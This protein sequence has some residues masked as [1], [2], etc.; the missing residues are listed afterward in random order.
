MLSL[1]AV[2]LSFAPAPLRAPQ[3]V[4]R[5]GAVS[6]ES[7]GDLKALADKCNPLVG[8]WDPMNLAEYDQ[9]SQ[10]EE[11]AIGFL[12]HA[13]IKHGRVA[14]AAF[15]GYCLQA[16]GAHFPWGLTDS[17]SFGDISA[18]G[19]PN[20]QWDALPTLAKLQIIAAIGLLEYFGE[21]D[22]AL[23]NSGEKHYM[24]GGTPGFYPS[25][26]SAGVPHP[27]P[28]DLWD[29]FGFTKGMSAE[30]KAKSLKAEINNGRL[31]MIGIMGFLAAEKVPG[32]VPFLDGLVA[33]YSG[34]VMAPFL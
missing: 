8:F 20:E 13:E 16:N 10:G 19:Y 18:A 3:S 7:A 25:L 6:M 15:V 12:R 23:G 27:V 33:P 21:S 14:M 30:K 17:V 9:W 34:D 26:K 11:A 31:A 4:C 1:S 24:K 22:F 28:L 29:P 5:A 2:A 32:S